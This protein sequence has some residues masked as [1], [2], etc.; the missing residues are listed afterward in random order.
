MQLTH[1]NDILCKSVVA[2]LFEHAVRIEYNTE[3]AEGFLKVLSA[4]IEFYSDP[5]PFFQELPGM[6][7]E[8][9]LHFRQPMINIAEVYIH[10]I[11]S[12][13]TKVCFPLQ[14]ARHAPTPDKCTRAN[15]RRI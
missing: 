10:Q 7:E 6:S 14:P 15:S 11:C 2:Q 13:V 9:V 8:R 4:L 3:S 1:T 5:E 12:A